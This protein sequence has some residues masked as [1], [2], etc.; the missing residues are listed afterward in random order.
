MKT[1]K[2]YVQPVMTLVNV[3]LQ[4]MIAASGDSALGVGYGTR[5]A[6]ESLSRQGSFWD[7]EE[8][9]Q[10]LANSSFSFH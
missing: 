10:L 4:T 8:E 2:Q 5:S 3:Q 9:Q 1:R 6:S 7:D